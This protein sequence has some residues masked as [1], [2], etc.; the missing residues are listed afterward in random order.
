LKGKRV[1]VVDDVITAG[2]AIRGAVSAIEEAG[3]TVVG[4]VVALDRMERIGGASAE[5][6]K[7]SAIMEVRKEMGVEVLAILNLDELIVGVTDE[8]ERGRML[9]YREKYGAVEE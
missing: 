5:E 9:E 2:T 1:L 8:G 4:I 6:R 7:G 3:G